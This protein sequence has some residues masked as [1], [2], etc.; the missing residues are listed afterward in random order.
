MTR[1][2]DQSFRGEER[3]SRLN[4]RVDPEQPDG[5]RLLVSFIPFVEDDYWILSLDPDYRW[6]LVGSPDRQ[7]LWVLSRQSRLGRDT[8]RQLVAQAAQQGYRLMNCL[9]PYIHPRSLQ[10]TGIKIQSV[11]L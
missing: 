10:K 7:R 8:Y 6:A 2:L 3:V 4:A 11:C 5:S 9:K 1:C